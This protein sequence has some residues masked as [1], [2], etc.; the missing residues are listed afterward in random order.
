MN[1][2][3]MKSNLGRRAM[4][5]TLF[6]LASVGLRAQT[7]AP[8]NFESKM[9]ETKVYQLLDVRT[10]GEFSQGHLKDAV[11]MDYYRNDFKDQLSKLDKNK[12]VF[13]Y[14]AVGG[15][16]NAASGIMKSMGF[17]QVFDL[18]G[19]IRAWTQAQKPVVK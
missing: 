1:Y 8:Q 9:R 2:R 7:L 5:S 12:P 17:K 15:R 10:E 6:I 18:Q 11:S 19:G 4:M 14:C 16:S 3:S 13:V